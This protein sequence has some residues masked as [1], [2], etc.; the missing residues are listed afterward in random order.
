MT[1]MNDIDSLS[2]LPIGWDGYGGLPIKQ[3]VI[4]KAKEI[5]AK[6][7]EYGWQAVPIGGI[8]DAMQLE[9]HSKQFDIEIYIEGL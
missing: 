6:L 1:R 8:G 5:A 9:H 4:D 2:N 3:S 7:P